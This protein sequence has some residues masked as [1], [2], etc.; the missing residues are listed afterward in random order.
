MADEALNPAQKIAKAA[1]VAIF[2]A[3]LTSFYGKSVGDGSDQAEQAMVLLSRVIISWIG[4]GLTAV[5]LVCS[6]IALVKMREYGSKRVLGRSIV[7]LLFSSTVLF[8]FATALNGARQRAAA[9]E[10]L[11]REDAAQFEAREAAVKDG[12]PPPSSN[13][14]AMDK[15]VDEF[16][17][18]QVENTTGDDKIRAETASVL[19]RRLQE[20]LAAYGAASNDFTNAGG[21]DPTFRSAEELDRRIALLDRV[22]STSDEVDRALAG[23][24]SEL[25]AAMVSRGVAE[26]KA[27]AEAAKIGVSLRVE[28]Q[29]KIYQMMRE[30]HS[31]GIKYFT[32]FKQEW[33]AWHCKD[34]GAVVFDDSIATIRY[35]ATVEQVTKV[36]L[37]IQDF[38]AKELA[39]RRAKMQKQ[40]TTTAPN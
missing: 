38:Q 18:T 9:L 28:D 29:R 14:T 12:K 10:A 6:V 19:I 30:F 3:I 40:G 4:I 39:A 35:N 21:L 32:V 23:F 1:M 34:S 20:R 37:Q 22:L 2:A 16:L 24:V 8:G 7:A 36:R 11:R 5:A 15:R 13:T 33:G 26:K 31:V 17:R 25:T 27:S